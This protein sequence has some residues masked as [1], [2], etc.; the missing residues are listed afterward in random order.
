MGD[1]EKVVGE[2]AN[3]EFQVKGIRMFVV[4]RERGRMST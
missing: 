3:I 2:V 1:S 4:T